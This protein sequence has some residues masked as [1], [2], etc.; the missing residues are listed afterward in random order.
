MTAIYALPILIQM[1]N[2]LNFLNHGTNSDV[3]FFFFY[4][5]SGLSDDLLRIQC[6]G[7]F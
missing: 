6:D 7:Q 5:F 1:S 2:N 4:F 3:L